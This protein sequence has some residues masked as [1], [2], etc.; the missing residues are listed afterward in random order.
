MT[1]VN[2][3]IVI[4]ASRE[5]VDQ[6]AVHTPSRVPEWF[7]GIQTF[8]PDNIYPAVGGKVKVKY[9]ASGITFDITITVLEYEPLVKFVQE[10]D[11][12]ISG[13]QTWTYGDAAGGTQVNVSF[14]YHMPGGGVGKIV[15]KLIVERINKQNIEKSVENLKA[16][17]EG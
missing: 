6:I 8:E 12:M 17:V 9:K 7:P 5:E 2:S 3:S 13:V 16:V 1:V 14:D 10:M 15:D 4:N 11:G